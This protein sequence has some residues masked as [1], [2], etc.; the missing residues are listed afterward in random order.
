PLPM[1]LEDLLQRVEKEH[2][3]RALEQ[4]RYNKTKAAQV[5]G[6]PR[7][8]LYRRMESLGI[9]DREEQT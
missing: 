8:R 5:L 9:E 2:I 7:P 6:I 1:P 4:C 3:E